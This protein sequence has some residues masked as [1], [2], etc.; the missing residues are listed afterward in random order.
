MLYCVFIIIKVCLK[1]NYKTSIHVRMN[2]YSIIRNKYIFCCKISGHINQDWTSLQTGI[3]DFFLAQAVT[4]SSSE[5]RKTLISGL[6]TQYFSGGACPRLPS[7]EPSKYILFPTAPRINYKACNM[8]R[9]DRYIE[10][11]IYKQM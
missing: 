11:S 3:L 6:K 10:N 5:I 2:P 8:G 4:I 7:V 1:G 9:T